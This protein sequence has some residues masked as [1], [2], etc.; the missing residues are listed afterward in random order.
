MRALIVVLLS[1][2]VAACETMGPSGIKYSY[3]VKASFSE[4]KSYAWAPTAS[5]YSPMH[6]RDRLVEVNV[7]AFADEILSQKNF[8]RAPDKSDLMMSVS[9]EHDS[10][11]TLRR[12]DLYVYAT[13]AKELLWRGTAFGAIKTDAAAGE[14]KPAV[15]D[16]LSNFPPR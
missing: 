12:L 11:Y 2:A 14:L 4:R 10:S 3:D 9:Y 6:G 13:D 7:Q 15:Q 1:I 16:I 8:T 5:G